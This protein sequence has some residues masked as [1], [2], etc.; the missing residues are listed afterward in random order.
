MRFRWLVLTVTA[1]LCGTVH[2]AE[3]P[4]EL[5]T[6][7]WSKPVADAR[8]YAVRGRLVLCEKRVTAGRR[9]LALYVELQDASPFL[10][11]GMRLF[12]NFRPFQPD[13]KSGM[14]AEL[15]DKMGK[16]VPS[17]P[18]AFGGAVPMPGWVNLPTDATI[19]LR[20]SPFGVYRPNALA[21]APQ[22]DHLWILADDDP[23][24]YSLSATVVVDSPVEP[25]AGTEHTWRGTLALPALRIRNGR[26]AGP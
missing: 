18:F 15:R 23:K 26:S 3:G 9:E 4:Q 5:A 11:N 8:G 13:Q 10:G 25:E 6:G 7:A 2:A 19:R 22:M 12:C 16:L 14:R 24:E 20:T 17:Q 21:L 1:A